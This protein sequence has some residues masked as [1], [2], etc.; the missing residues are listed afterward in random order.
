MRPTI[1]SFSWL[2]VPRRRKVAMARR[3]ASASSG[4]NLAASMASRIACS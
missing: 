3:S 1:F 4:V 2:S